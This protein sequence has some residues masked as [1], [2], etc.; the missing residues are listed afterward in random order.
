METFKLLFSFILNTLKD[1][2]ST[3]LI[4]F[5]ILIPIMIITKLLQQFGLI[6]YLGMAL[7]PLMELVGL[8][9]KMGLVWA[10][11]M[12]TNL[13]GAMAV[14]ASISPG[15]ELTVA[16]VT[17]LTTML[18]VAHA[19]P[20]ELRI[21]Q[22]AGARIGVML[23]LRLSGALVL[24]FI[25]HQI[26]S[27]TGYLGQE[28]VMLWNPP[29]QD[30]SWFGWAIGTAKGLS[31]IFLII[32]TM[33][34]CMALLKKIKVVDFLTWLLKPILKL[35]GMTRDA[36]PITII[37]MMLGISYGGGLI[38]KE[39]KSGSLSAQDVFYSLSLMGLCH[40]L[41][42][43]TML[44]LLIGGHHSGVFWGRFVFALLVV[45][46]MVYFLKRIND[47]DFNKYFCKTDS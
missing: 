20:V 27:K 12:V 28:N 3:C 36:A 34:S 22:K 2:L 31:W 26:Y 44:M 11:G 38:I 9:G 15:M 45:A 42:E 46:T 29:A 14:F 5:R 16:Q 33:L 43:D 23:L 1:T 32:L 4:L 39:A 18:L 41:F 6:D 19:L 21:A 7:S 35:L 37:G 10:T 17:V 24:G 40:S 30:A 47:S 8:P 25:L 13:Y